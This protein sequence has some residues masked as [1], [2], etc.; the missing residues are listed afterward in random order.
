MTN[1]EL[2]F[3]LLSGEKTE[4]IPFFP[5]ITM[6]YQVHRVKEG[7]EQLY[8]PGE[9]IPDD[10]PIHKL[11]GTMP[12]KYKNF[13][14]LDFYRHFNWGCPLHIYR[15]RKSEYKNISHSSRKED[16]KTI[17][18]LNTPLGSLREVSMMAADGSSA[19]VEHY[20]K[21]IEDLDIIK[22]SVE[23][24]KYSAKNEFI[25]DTLKQLGELGVADVTINRSP[26]G[27]LVHNYMGMENVIYAMA[28][29]PDK[30][31][32]FLKFQEEYDLKVIKLAA[33]SPAKIVILSDHADE[34]LIAPNYFRDF[35]VPFY[36]K[37]NKILHAAGKIVSTHM[38]GNFKGDFP[39]LEDTAL[40]LLDGCTPYP[41][42]NYTPAELAAALPKNMY[43]YCGVPCALFIGEG[44]FGKVKENAE[45]IIKALKG[46]VI[47]NV[48]DIMPSNGNFDLLVE[49]SDSLKE[50]P[51]SKQF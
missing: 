34:N 44:G 4:K 22:Y 10:A 21:T 18:T 16:N 51:V 32:D 35:C 31:L 19:V 13:T 8:N 37:A 5:D 17:E 7:A 6:W 41:M 26:F 1:R 43:A 49:L 29:H 42:N 27:K 50:F 45:S 40:D 2:F 30:I 3:K 14:F 28:D 46:K 39:Y 47:L 36:Q 25:T 24:T 20:A 9:L 33:E 38:D 11:S 12:E 48:G 23:N 15:W